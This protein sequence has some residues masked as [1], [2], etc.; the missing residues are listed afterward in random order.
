M[1]VAKIFRKMLDIRI[2]CD[3]IKHE[4]GQANIENVFVS[5][6]RTYFIAKKPRSKE[7]SLKKKCCLL[8]KKSVKVRQ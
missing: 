3:I 2:I 5:N 7:R 6:K 1:F 8:F 4:I